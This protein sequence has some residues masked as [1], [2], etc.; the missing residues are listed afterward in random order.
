M[1]GVCSGSVEKKSGDQL[2]VIEFDEKSIKIW[3]L[4]EPISCRNQIYLVMNRSIDGQ[5][6]N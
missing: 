4:V 3:K 6:G 1:F 5:I 2:M